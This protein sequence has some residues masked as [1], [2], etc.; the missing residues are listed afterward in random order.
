VTNQTSGSETVND[1]GAETGEVPRL[2]LGTNQSR[3]RLWLTRVAVFSVTFVLLM[4]LFTGL[5]TIVEKF[6]ILLYTE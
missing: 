6:F 4:S 5:A 2:G 1:D 3:W